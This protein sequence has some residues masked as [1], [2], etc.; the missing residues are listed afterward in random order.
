[1]QGIARYQVV[2]H[3][4]RD[5]E[6]VFVPDRSLPGVLPDWEPILR[7][8][9]NVLDP[10]TRFRVTP[11]ESIPQKEGCHKTPLIVTCVLDLPESSP[12]P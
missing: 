6:I 2:Q 11:M 4:L 5:L 8:L 10:E 3:T 9:G 1:M 12:A 7:Q